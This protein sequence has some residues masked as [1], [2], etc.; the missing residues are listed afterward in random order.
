[1]HTTNRIDSLVLGKGTGDALSVNEENFKV[2][3]E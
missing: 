1:M 2:V 3:L